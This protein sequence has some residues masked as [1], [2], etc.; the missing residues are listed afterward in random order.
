MYHEQ[1][2]SCGPRMVHFVR[3]FG[4]GPG[5]GPF[6][7]GFGGPRGGGLRFG[8]IF[9]DG[10]LRLVVLSL[11]NEGPRHG[12]DV[13]KALEERSGGFYSPSPGVVY[14]TLTFLEEAG[15]ATAASEGAKRVFTITDAGRAYLAENRESVQSVMETMARFGAKMGKAREWFDWTD[16]GPG[17]GA[18]VETEIE[19]ETVTERSGAMTDLDRA[20]RRLRALIVAATEGT[21]ADQ[22]RVAEILSRAADEILGKRV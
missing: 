22:Q 7:P 21:E 12:Y 11:L 17:H 18:T 13:I 3:R 5:F 2:D 9:R 4:G 19:T 20:R 10:D 1:H 16:S 15:Y 6:G 14:P 8:R